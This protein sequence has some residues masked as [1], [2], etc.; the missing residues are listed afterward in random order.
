MF[1]HDS[2]VNRFFKVSDINYAS[3]PVNTGTHCSHAGCLIQILLLNGRLQP[4]V[5]GLHNRADLIK[6][7]ILLRFPAQQL[8]R[9]LAA[10][11]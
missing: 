5:L 6:D 9:P 7:S 8:G 10:S 3:I 1:L 11:P 2:V 4:I